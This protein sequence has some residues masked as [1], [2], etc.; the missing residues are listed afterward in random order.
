VT[1]ADSAP[2]L[3]LDTGALTTKIAVGRAGAAP[4]LSSR[5]T[6]QLSREDACSGALGD[7]TCALGGPPGRVCVAVP[8]SW[9]DGDL[10]AAQAFEDLRHHLEDDLVVSPLTWVGQLSAAALA[11]GQSPSRPPGRY[12]VCDLGGTGVRTA[13]I[14]TA[15]QAVRPLAVDADRPGG[16]L[17]F[18][19]RLRAALPAGQPEPDLWFTAA[20]QQQRRAAL[21]LAQATADPAFRDTW[22]YRV[23]TT[24]ASWEIT[25]GLLIDSFAE[26][27]RQLRASV[28]AVLAGAVPDVA[29][30]TGGFGW[31]P[32]AAQ[33]VAETAGI[34]PEILGPHAAVQGA[35]LIARGAAR[36]RS[37]QRP[38]ASLPA[39]QI[40]D[41]R[42]EDLRLPLP[43]TYSLARS[44]DEPVV[45]D[46]AEVTLD[47]A[48][49]LRTIPLPGL[50]P[51]PCRIGLRPSR[52]G[53]ALLVIRPDHP[54][55][56]L[57]VSITAIDL[58]HTDGR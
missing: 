20:E 54:G 21:V 2:V 9:L 53:R 16:W 27:A 44:G 11:A 6:A 5:P 40:R 1:I 31:F 29:V 57:T 30:L 48:G 10:S 22:A 56:G 24:T 43:W 47:I 25:A 13:L 17:A 26:V 4:D 15:E 32:L 38:D 33:V 28:S 37:P 49:T 36:R 58:E 50:V 45:L 18:R 8:E 46:S 55:A 51:G 41:G 12:L 23:G 35:L 39:H 7:A 42:L 3:A 19:D 14:E 52:P 34:A